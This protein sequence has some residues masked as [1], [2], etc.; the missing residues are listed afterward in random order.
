MPLALILSSFVAGS[1]V[2]GFPQALVLQT[3]GVDPVLVPTVLFG[4]RPGQGRAPGGAA[5]EAETFAGM[6]EGVEANGLFGLF[7]AVITGY[8]ASEAQV[9]V[10]ARTIDAVRAAGRHGA[11]GPAL[12]V[13]VDPIMGDHPGG[14]Y[15]GE[16]TAAAI[17][18]ELLPRA[19]VL[20]PNLWELDRLT[21][22]PAGTPE[23]VAQAARALGR[24]TLVTSVP[25]G[26]GAIGAVYAD[27]ERALVFSHR[28]VPEAPNGTGDVVT[29]VLA[30]EMIEGAP[31][32]QAAERAVRAAAETVFAAVEWRAP[33]LPLV[34]L[35]ARL[36]RPTA[37]L[38]V[39]RLDAGPPGGA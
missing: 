30:A 35:G 32:P 13:V 4:R 34:A 28:R 10:A 2:G 26:E 36:R 9:L 3:F 38:E 21:G 5:V 16:A 7:D 22:T 33:E 14:L 18:R 20:T 37:P 17:A 27:E 24:P 25:T 1:R 23:A 11:F 15:V 8:F 31:A 39:R 6:L 12:T 29:A 19:N